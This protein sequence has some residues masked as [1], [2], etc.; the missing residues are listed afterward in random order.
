MVAHLDE[1]RLNSPPIKGMSLK[2]KIAL[3]VSVLFAFFMINMSYFT[4][5]YFERTYKV[6]IS[7][8][9]FTLVSGIAIAL[10]TAMLLFST[11][12]I[13]RRFMS[14]LA[15]MT[16]HFEHLP[17]SLEQDRHIHIYCA[18][19]LGVLA[20]TFNS[21]IDTLDRQR[22]ELNEQKICIENERALLETIM[23]AI[24]D[25]IFHKDR[26]NIYRG[27]NKAFANNLLGRHKEDIIGKCDYD[28][29]PLAERAAFFRQTDSEVMQICNPC[30]YEVWVELADGGKVLLETVKV[31]LRDAQ[32]GVTGVIGISRDITER[33]L[34][35][36]KLHKQAELLESEIAERQEAQEAFAVKQLQLEELNHSLED[37]VF[38]TVNELRQK[39][40]TLIQQSRQ[41]AMGEMINYI[42]HQWRNPLNN[43]GLI[44]QSL[45]L[46]L[47]NH[48]INEDELNKEI[49]K[50]MNIVVYMSNTIDDFRN[51]FRKD[52]QRCLFSIN[53]AVTTVLSF[54]D[55]SLKNNRIVVSF[56]AEDHVT[57]TGYRNE[58]VQVILN[59]ISNAL[60][61]MLERRVKQPIIR[62]NLCCEQDCSVL[63]ITD[64]GGG[65]PADVLPRIFDLYFT[66][67]DQGKGTGIGLYMSKVIIEQHMG[68]RLIVHNIDDG[69]EF[70]IELPSG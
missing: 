1:N 41:A 56:S 50:V 30:R 32:G 14:P 58:Y 13:M 54:I 44:V 57:T 7:V 68:G 20:N 31:P 25:P 55:A 35:E 8:Q 65:M 59:I 52:K 47:K 22:G 10:G 27:C 69:A 67:K 45:G 64:N 21:M 42:A 48:D 66:T 19:E 60:D 2:T 39:D 23:D 16:R 26:D 40:Q 61:I 4:L 6:S 70:R 33:K 15:A 9:Q 43:I 24:P 46:C 34:A 51:F 38:K 37:I 53:E 12:V 62:I 11:W 3:A 5:S 29:A 63:T 18:E 17:N 28:F 36:E 49:S